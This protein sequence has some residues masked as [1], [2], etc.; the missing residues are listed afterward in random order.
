MNILYSTGCP[1]CEVLKIK[2]KEKGIEYVEC[3]DI[4][5]MRKLN[6]DEVPVLLY[7]NQLLKFKDAVVAI[8]NQ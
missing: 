6:I 7:N 1:K 2:L 4:E 5:K 3:N 8:N